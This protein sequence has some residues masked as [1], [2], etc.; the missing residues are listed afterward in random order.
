MFSFD[1][2]MAINNVSLRARVGHFNA[3][4]SPMQRNSE[5]RY[6]LSFLKI[7]LS[8][9]YFTFFQINL[10]YLYST[11]HNISSTFRSITNHL[12]A[13]NVEILYLIYMKGLLNCCGA[14]EINPGPN[15]SPLTFCHWNLNGIAAHDFI[16]ISLLQGYTTDGN[17]DIICLSETFLNSSLDGDDRLK[18]KVII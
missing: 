11:F 7:I 12:E 13:G 1:L 10:L 8:L 16:K 18:L 9:I 2:S 6:H 5:M 15:K 4:K 14:I 17:I 3:F